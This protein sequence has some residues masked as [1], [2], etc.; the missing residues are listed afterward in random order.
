[1]DRWTIERQTI[2]LFSLR[3][4]RETVWRGERF[5]ERVEEVVKW[6]PRGCLGVRL[7]RVNRKLKP[8]KC[9]GEET[10]F[11]FLSLSVYDLKQTF[12]REWSRKPLVDFARVETESSVR[13]FTFSIIVFYSNFEQSIFINRVENIFSIQQ[14]ILIVDNR[15]KYVFRDH[16]FIENWNVSSCVVSD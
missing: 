1:M 2:T 15:R 11:T 9:E 3:D 16:S 4:K 7:E 6:R 8:F 5:G 12:P 13:L 14:V 10:V